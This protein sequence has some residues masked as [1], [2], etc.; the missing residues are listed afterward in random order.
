MKKLLYVMFFIALTFNSCHG[1]ADKKEKKEIVKKE[2]ADE[3]KPKVDIKVNKKYDEN[4][5]LIAFD[6]TYTSYYA[7]DK[8]DKALLDSLFRD[9]KPSFNRKFPFMKEDYF[10]G[11][12]YSDTLIYNDFFHEDFFRKRMEMNDR[13]MQE[14]MREMDSVKNAYFK[15]HA[16]G[17]DRKKKSKQEKAGK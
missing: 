6:S 12:F 7:T 11:L 10:D 8:P 1:Q 5:N 3:G 15:S 13:Y 9:F 16:K 17:L 2:T 14:M 4:G